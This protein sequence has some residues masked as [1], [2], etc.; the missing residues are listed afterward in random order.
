MLLRMF[1]PI[2]RGLASNRNGVIVSH[3]FRVSRHQLLARIFGS[4][5]CSRTPPLGF[6]IA[7]TPETMVVLLD[8]Q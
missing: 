3:I 7:S 4:V 6:F 8:S 2:F 5:V 1:S